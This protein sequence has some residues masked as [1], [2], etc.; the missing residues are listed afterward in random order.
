MWILLEKR[1]N[2]GKDDDLVAEHEGGKIYDFRKA[3]ETA[4]K[5]AGLSDIRLH[6]LR[7]AFAAHLVVCGV[8]SSEVQILLGHSERRMTERY[9]HLS[10]TH[11]MLAVRVLENLGST[12]TERSG[13]LD[14][15]AESDKS[16]SL[17]L[18]D[19][20]SMIRPL[21]QDI[22]SRLFENKEE[23]CQKTGIRGIGGVS[24]SEAIPI[25]KDLL[26][27]SCRRSR[28]ND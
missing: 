12:K 28:G 18:V 24:F 27:L 5:R 10:P 20:S 2:R 8:D 21:A 22:L 16:I 26:G 3:F 11:K 17:P 25:R 6:D 13:F 19:S 4:R 14:D 9:S 15:R 23:E 7:H 1:S